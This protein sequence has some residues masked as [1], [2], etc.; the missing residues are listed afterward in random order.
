M[1]TEEGSPKSRR[2]ETDGVLGA[3]MKRDESYLLLLPPDLL[4]SALCLR[5]IHV[6]R[7]TA[8]RGLKHR[9]K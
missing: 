1:S 6:T 8:G 7:S 5:L 2:H 3:C 9:V 4:H